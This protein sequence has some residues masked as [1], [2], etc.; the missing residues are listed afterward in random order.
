[1]IG[2]A[3][4]AKREATDDFE[5]AMSETPNRG[6]VAGSFVSDGLIVPRFPENARRDLE[7]Y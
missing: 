6:W 3:R 1:M 2:R 7:N 4:K 5:R